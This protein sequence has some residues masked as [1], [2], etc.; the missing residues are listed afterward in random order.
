[1]S[2]N[3]WDS[4]VR[5]AGEQPPLSIKAL[6]VE[7]YKS[8]AEDEALP[9][10]NRLSAAASLA[11]LDPQAAAVILLRIAQGKVGRNIP[12]GHATNAPMQALQHLL[13]LDG[14]MAIQAIYSIVATEPAEQTQL[15]ALKLVIS[16]PNLNIQAAAAM[17]HSVA[18]A[19]VTANVRLTAANLL[20]QL[21]QQPP[22]GHPR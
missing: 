4:Y 9:P 15:S 19:S 22:R 1:M 16:I 17:L 20:Q 8:I 7:S 5:A 6:A 11:Q 13:R 12:P 2:T 21:L 18:T 3:N 14:N 10:A